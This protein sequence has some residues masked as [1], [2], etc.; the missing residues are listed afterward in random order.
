MS[1]SLRWSKP[2]AKVTMAS[3]T[4]QPQL[5]WRRYLCIRGR[6]GASELHF[7]PD[8]VQVIKA[9]LS[10]HKQKLLSVSSTSGDMRTARCEAVLLTWNIAWQDGRS[11]DHARK[12]HPESCDTTTQFSLLQPASESCFYTSSSLDWVWG[13][14]PQRLFSTSLLA[15]LPPHK[16]LL[17]VQSSQSHYTVHRE[18]WCWE[19]GCL[20]P[21]V[22]CDAVQRPS[23]IGSR[24]QDRHISSELCPP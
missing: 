24:K 6:E 9:S 22:R 4:R 5:W 18:S 21:D 10:H 11:W 19:M 12:W 14:D 1:V 2:A 20:E 7:N 16:I 3:S 17:T 8:F 13:P 15:M 23:L